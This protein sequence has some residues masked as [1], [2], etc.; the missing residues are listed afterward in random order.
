MITLWRMITFGVQNFWRN[1]WL[2]L[3]TVLI[4]T[5]NLFLMTLV[6]GVNVVG[7]QTLSAVQDQVNL[8][9]YFT[10][11]TSEDRVEEVR[12]ELLARPDVEDV[13]LIT[14]AERLERL[15]KTQGGDDL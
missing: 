14:R 13:Q 4:V 11:T 2:S 8:S 1:I 12:Q 3:V 9:V 7:Q 5:L 6:L 15:K 10:A